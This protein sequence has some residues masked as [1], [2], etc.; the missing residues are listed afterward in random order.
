MKRNVDLTENRLFSSIPVRTIVNSQ[1][2][3]C[4]WNIKTM[5]IRSGDEFD[6]EHQRESIIAT[7]NRIKRAEISEYRRMDSP[8]YCDCCGARMNVKPWDKEFGICHKCAV[9][10]E[11][12]QDRC[13]W[14][15][16]R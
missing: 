13:L 1:K 6:L 9:R 7:G 10:F 12:N 15:R 2:E 14:R 4:P 16:K 11:K 3:R 8:N 5:F